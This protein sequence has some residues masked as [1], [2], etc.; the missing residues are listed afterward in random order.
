[1]FDTNDE[2][3]D[4]CS[5]WAINQSGM[6]LQC[7]RADKN[8]FGKEN[9]NHHEF[10][11]DDTEKLRE[12]LSGFKDRGYFIS[13]FEKGHCRT[14]CLSQ[15]YPF[16]VGD[17]SYVITGL[18]M[19]NEK[20]DRV[21]IDFASEIEIKDDFRSCKRRLLKHIHEI[22]QDTWPMINI[23]TTISLDGNYG[24]IRLVEPVDAEI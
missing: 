4:L 5:G 12:A 17:K 21:C 19:I 9:V 3:I 11:V 8:S 14:H 24:P 20:M 22:V 2:F 23:E 7:L 10:I 13:I 15:D 16:K 1:M 18:R 6:E